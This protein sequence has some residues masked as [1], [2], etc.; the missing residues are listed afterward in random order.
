MKL[1]SYTRVRLTDAQTLIYT[2]QA[3]QRG[4]PLSTYLRERLERADRA[5]EE[6]S[7][8][9]ASLMELGDAVDE[10]R[11]ERP[12]DGHASPAPSQPADDAM[13]IETLLLLRGLA[14]PQKQQMVKAEVERQGLTPWNGS[15]VRNAPRR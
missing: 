12:A 13:A 10:L 3:E 5:D 2:A 9:R 4:V 14:G 6:L 7:S 8:I 11:R 15:E 1:D